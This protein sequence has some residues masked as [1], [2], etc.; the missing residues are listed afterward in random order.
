MSGTQHLIDVASAS[1]E[2]R[3]WEEDYPDTEQESRLAAIAT[4]NEEELVSLHIGNIQFS[5][6]GNIFELAKHLRP[7]H[8]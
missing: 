8:W 2:E 7:Q 1:E 3:E 6:L 5:F 4:F